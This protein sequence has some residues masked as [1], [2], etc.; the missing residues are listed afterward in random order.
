MNIFLCSALALAGSSIFA[1][2]NFLY[3]W[4]GDSSM[5]QAS[6]EIS[7]DEQQPGA[8]FES[9]TF[10]DTFTVIAPDHA[11]PPNTFVSG[12]DASGY[13]PPLQLSVFMKD[14]SF[15]NGILATSTARAIY[16]IAEYRLSDGGVTAQE[17]GYWTFAQIPEPNL[18]SFALLI[19]GALLCRKPHSGR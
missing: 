18:A 14:T 1:Q 5:F 19:F 15:S 7:A 3:A 6:F 17:F 8:Y 2:G 9:G 12:D 10:K 13:G 4:H 16:S 11:F